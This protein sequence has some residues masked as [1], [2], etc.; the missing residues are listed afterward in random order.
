MFFLSWKETVGDKRYVGYKK[1]VFIS[2]RGS[3]ENFDSEW[4]RS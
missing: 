4:K 3:D 2:L 1:K